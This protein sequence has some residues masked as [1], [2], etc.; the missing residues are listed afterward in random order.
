MTDRATRFHLRWLVRKDMPGILAILDASN[1]P[2]TEATLLRYLRHRQHIG[3]TLEHDQNSVG[4]AFYCLKE[5][6]LL[7]RDIVIH[8]RYRRIGAARY[9]IDKIKD[10]VSAHPTRTAI[11]AIV[12]EHNLVGQLFL[13][14]NGFALKKIWREYYV[15]PMEDA[16]GF[17]WEM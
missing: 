15:S 9:I 4:V 8:P 17:R 6:H 12:R 3:M 13:K 16:Y 5:T 2:W 7:L 10:K 14:G 1:H 11:H